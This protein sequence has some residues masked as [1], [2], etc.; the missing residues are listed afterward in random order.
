ML[1]FSSYLL[2][3]YFFFFTDTATTEIYTLS[4]HDALPIFTSKGYVAD[5]ARSEPFSTATTRSDTWR[6]PAS[7]ARRSSQASSSAR[8][9]MATGSDRAI[10]TEAGPSSKRH[11]PTHRAGSGSPAGAGGSSAN[12]LPVRPPPQGFSRGWL[13]SKTVTEAPPPARRHASRAP[14]GPAPTIPTFIYCTA[15]R[16]SSGVAV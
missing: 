14:A 10:C 4:L 11:D 3:Y 9:A 8:A 15:A 1:C 5:A 13:G 6:A 7:R 2:S 12:D 16:T